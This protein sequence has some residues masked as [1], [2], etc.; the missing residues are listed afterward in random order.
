MELK[1]AAITD[2]APMATPTT[3]GQPRETITPTRELQEL[4]TP[5]HLEALEV[6]SIPPTTELVGKP[7]S[8]RLTERGGHKASPFCIS[9]TVNSPPFTPYEEDGSS[10]SV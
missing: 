5:P 3:T 10:V 7:I 8:I 1:L 4:E 6:V 2:P 9:E